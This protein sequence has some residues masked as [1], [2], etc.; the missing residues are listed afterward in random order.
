MFVCRMAGTSATDASGTFPS[1]TGAASE[2]CVCVCLCVLSVVHLAARVLVVY[3]CVWCFLCC[4]RRLMQAAANVPGARA[5]PHMAFQGGYI[6]VRL[7]F[8]VC[9]VSC[10]YV[11][12]VL[13]C[14]F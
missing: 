13:S 9:I 4:T 8:C 12:C 1:T 3:L 6:W 10:V 2:V 7:S 5:S 14:M 11:G